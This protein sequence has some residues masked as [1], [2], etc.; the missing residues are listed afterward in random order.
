MQPDKVSRR[1]WLEQKLNFLTASKRY[2]IYL[3]IAL[4]SLLLIVFFVFRSVLQGS[5]QDESRDIQISKKS[6]LVLPFKNL[7]NRG[8][9]QY[10]AD[11]IME[12][13]LNNLFIIRGLDVIS[14]STAEYFQGKLMS[15]SEIAGKLHVSYV[16]EGS[17]HKDGNVVKIIAELF[18]ATV[19]KHIMSE[20]YEGDISDIFFIQSK[21]VK[22]VAD[23]LGVAPT[24]EDLLQIEKIPTQN[25]EAYDY[26]LRARS[27][28]NKASY[29]QQEYF[30]KE[31]FAGSL[32]YYEKA[33]AADTNF[34]GALAGLADAWFS[35]ANWDRAGS[36]YEG[37]LKAK[38]CSNKALEI[39]PY[40]AE[41]HAVKGS[42]LI[43]PDRKFE[44]GRMELLVSHQLNPNYPVVDLQYIQ[45]L[46]ITGPIDRARLYINQAMEREPY[47]W[48]LHNLNSW[49]YYLEEKYD[50]SID[51]CRKALEFN[52]DY[53]FNN[54]LLFLNY[55][56]TGNGAEAS[57]ELQ[58]I[59]RSVTK[60]D[61][62]DKEI[63]DV[64]NTSGVQGLFSWL[65]DLNIKKPVNATGLNGE[66]FY[67]SWLYA[68]I[69]D[70]EKSLIWLA[71]SLQSKT[72]DNAFS[73]LIATNPDFDILRNDPRFIAI[74]YQLGLTYY[75]TREPKPNVPKQLQKHQ[76][77]L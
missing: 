25:P 72:L 32:K 9:D 65:I 73:D 51:A 11:G 69:G 13:I 68:F 2:I 18:D 49:I 42:C 23:K 55:A 36:F 19:K 48:F 1:K 34:A 15:E 3:S 43:W 8:E 40:C 27:M 5:R 62:Y 29:S 7:N 52:P 77:D 44:E 41:A 31:A 47:F 22:A 20:K 67:I 75:D 30:D 26:Y 59:L 4:L 63:M 76:S 14:R 71:K 54:W 60:S 45:L 70:S 56:K 10:F 28:F 66:P 37:I 38:E 58:I 57:K 35:M 24:Y 6:L 17:V 74:V 39:D 21:I 12:N 46:M 33:V 16:L 53:I 64:Y 50:E 61:I